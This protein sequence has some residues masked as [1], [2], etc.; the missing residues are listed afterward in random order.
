MSYKLRAAGYELP[1]LAP[2]KR[3]ETF[4]IEMKAERADVQETIFIHRAQVPILQ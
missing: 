3:K 4:E 2:P 1:G